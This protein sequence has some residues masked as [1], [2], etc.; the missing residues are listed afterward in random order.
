MDH[1]QPEFQKRSF[2]EQTLQNS[3]DM[4]WTSSIRQQYETQNSY[5]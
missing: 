2:Y 1:A 4:D 5:F 3:E